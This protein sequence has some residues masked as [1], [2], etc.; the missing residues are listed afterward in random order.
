MPAAA[1]VTAWFPPS[2][3]HDPGNIRP[4]RR[5]N[6]HMKRM[7]GARGVWEAETGAKEKAR[8]TRALP[9]T[10]RPRK[11]HGHRRYQLLHPDRSPL[12]D[13]A[14]SSPT[15]NTTEAGQ[16]SKR[17]TV[18]DVARHATESTEIRRNGC[19][20][21]SSDGHPPRSQSPPPLTEAAVV[22]PP[23]PSL[24]S[25]RPH[26]RRARRHSLHRRRHNATRP[27]ES[28]PG[29]GRQNVSSR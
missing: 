1:C 17:T 13:S 4:A 22:S 25:C 11:T 15:E 26:Q 18:H 27:C 16:S 23:P 8:H 6:L 20:T 2:S 29:F 24:H 9:S 28:G 7:G 19:S 3:L 14:L 10:Q 21:T 12:G 5:M